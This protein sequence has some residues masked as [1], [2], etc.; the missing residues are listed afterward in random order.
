MLHSFCYFD[1]VPFSPL[2]SQDL[3]ASVYKFSFKLVRRIV[4]DQDNNFYLISL[5]FLS[6][7]LLILKFTQQPGG[8][9]DIVWCYSGLQI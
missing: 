7:C 8:Q 2:N 3:I 5:S 9:S 4:L 6:T 1:V